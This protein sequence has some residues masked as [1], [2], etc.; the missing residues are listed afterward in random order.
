MQGRRD[1]G[2]FRERELG[3]GRK[4]EAVDERKRRADRR[5][6]DEGEGRADRRGADE[7][8]TADRR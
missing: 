7:E 5:G 4:S 2:W 1:Q 6:V 3:M 8:T